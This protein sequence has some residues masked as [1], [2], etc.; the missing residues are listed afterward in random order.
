MTLDDQYRINDNEFD[1]ITIYY[2]IEDQK[3]AYLAF[4]LS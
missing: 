2:D 4:V 1:I 3:I